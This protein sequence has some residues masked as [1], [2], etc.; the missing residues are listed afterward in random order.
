MN[1]RLIEK[2]SFI[3]SLFCT[4][5]CLVGDKSTVRRVHDLGRNVVVY[6]KPG[7]K[8]E[9]I[10][11]KQFFEAYGIFTEIYYDMVA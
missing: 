6:E 2:T 8:V 3:S 11:K 4:L 10:N 1:F 9:G 5:L 7:R